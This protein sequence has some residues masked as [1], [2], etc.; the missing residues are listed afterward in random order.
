M[1]TLVKT[2]HR[3]LRPHPDRPA[4]TLWTPVHTVA[5]RRAEPSVALGEAL[6]NNRVSNTLFDT[7]S[8]DTVRF[9]LKNP[10]HIN[11]EN[12]IAIEE[13]IFPTTGEI[14]STRSKLRNMRVIEWSHGI[15][16]QGS[17]PKFLFNQNLTPITLND[18]NQA[19]DEISNLLDIDIRNGTIRR[20]DIAANLNL[21]RPIGDYLLTLSS[22]TRCTRKAYKNESVYFS[23]GSKSLVFYDKLAEMRHNRKEYGADVQ[24][25]I[26]GMVS[27]NILRYEYQP[28][29]IDNIFSHSLE[30]NLLTNKDVNVKMMKTWKHNYDSIIKSKFSLSS[31]QGFSTIHD[32]T[33]SVLLVGIQ[34]L[35]GIDGIMEQIENRVLAGESTRVQKSRFKKRLRAVMVNGN[36]LGTKDLIEEFDSKVEKAYENTLEML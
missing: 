24:D 23:N 20:I 29:D 25:L 10:C 22:A 15:T 3:Q 18:V 31:V 8:Y 17:L 28:K 14:R 13:S 30:A 7:L 35:G 9:Y 21:D 16:I 26:D 11:H 33:N 1:N 34:S 4:R 2:N 19:I 36:T 5:A 32:L 27:S 12:L 6:N